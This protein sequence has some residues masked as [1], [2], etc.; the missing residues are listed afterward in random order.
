MPFVEGETLRERI[1]RE[2]QLGVEE[3]VAI[4]K[5]VADAL[6]YAHRQGIIHRDIKPATSSSR[7]VGPSS[8]TS[9]SP[10]R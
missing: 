4:V 10:W 9:V 3:S 5:E 6:A 7:A 2:Q 8:P 1:E